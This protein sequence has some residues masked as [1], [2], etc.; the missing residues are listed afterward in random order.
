MN[1]SEQR[2]LH[3]AHPDVPEP[4]TSPEK[5]EQ[6]DTHTSEERLQKEKENVR[7]L[8]DR[9]SLLTETYKKT[10]IKQLSREFSMSTFNFE[11]NKDTILKKNQPSAERD[12][13]II[14]LIKQYSGEIEEAHQKN[15][16]T[17][18]DLQANSKLMASE[19]ADYTYVIQEIDTSL[20][21]FEESLNEAGKP[22]EFLM[23]DATHS[24]NALSQ[25]HLIEKKIA[26]MKLDTPTKEAYAK[27]I[28]VLKQEMQKIE[29][30]AELVST[31]D[32]KQFEMVSSFS[33]GTRMSARDVL[34]ASL[35]E[36]PRFQGVRITSVSVLT[37]GMVVLRGSLKNEA[38]RST[39]ERLSTTVLQ[40]LLQINQIIWGIPSKPFVN[41]SLMKVESKK[42]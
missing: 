13:M 38:Q 15:L 19:D 39:T 3:W 6:K 8:Y 22:A 16:P 2:L 21:A 41:A 18:F 24:L 5:N 14:D 17:L 23:D 31:A 9:A 10:D 40:G 30:L 28:T 25:L 20:F 11:I 33:D 35:K 7:T 12:K 32:D 26:T 27:R 34:H 4:Q 37:S 42:E 1:F 36:D 29:K